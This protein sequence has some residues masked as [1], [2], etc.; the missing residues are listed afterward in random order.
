MPLQPPTPAF[1]AAAHPEEDNR[2][3]ARELLV[4]G[5]AV[6]LATVLLTAAGRNVTGAGRSCR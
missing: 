2:P 5:G 1:L 3:S 4:A 6:V